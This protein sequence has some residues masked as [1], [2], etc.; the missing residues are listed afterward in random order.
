MTPITPTPH[1][2]TASGAVALLLAPSVFHRQATL[3]A[4]RFILARL[5]AVLTRLT[6]FR[7]G[8]LNVIPFPVH[9]GF[10]LVTALGAP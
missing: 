7:R 5:L 4:A 1:G 3:S 9:G 2:I 10:G 8:L 6:A